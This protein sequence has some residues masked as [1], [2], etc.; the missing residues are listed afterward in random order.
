M[1]TYPEALA[2]LY[3]QLPMFQR[4]GAAAYKSDLSNTLALCEGLGHPEKSFKSIHV[5]GT[6]GKGSTASALASIFMECGYKTGLFTSPHLVDFRERIRI[7]GALIPEAE[8]VAFLEKS[9]ALIEQVQ[10]SFFELTCLMAFDHFRK[11]QV[12]IAI[13]EVGM[14]GRLDSTNVV[15]PELAV[16]TSIGMDH[17]Q[18]LGDTLEK[19]AAEKAGI[20][21]QG[22]PVVL[23]ENE[24]EVQQVISTMAESKASELI[25]VKAQSPGL[26]TD[27]GGIYQGENMR[28][29]HAAIKRM[30]QLGWRLPHSTVERAALNVMANTGLR[31]R[32]EKLSE[33]PK[34]IA[35][36]GHNEEG[37]ALVAQ[38]LEQEEFNELHVVW[39]MVADKDAAAILK[40]LPQQAHYY[41]CKPDIPRGKETGALLQEAEKFGLSGKA[42][43]S[44]SAA[45]ASAKMAAGPSDLVFVGGSVFV[46][47]EVL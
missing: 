44:V 21:K 14:G 26:K 34:V 47:A 1:M 31:G 2:F 38:M 17:Q 29:V 33:L 27:L 24:P 15:M 46:V 42:Y 30:R 4:V 8:V 45:F 18:F 11:E 43:P 5:A 37:V 13:L 23:S 12:D 7:N 20:I 3:S 36:V 10:P 6:N 19:I 35:D 40:L 41:W 28:T 16:I 9:K 22:V 25:T 32:W 39:G